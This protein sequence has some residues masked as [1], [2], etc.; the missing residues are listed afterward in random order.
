MK[1]IKLKMINFK[2]FRHAE[3]EFQDGLTG[4]I[5]NNGAGK[6]TI[7]EAILWSLYGNR[8][9]SIKKDFLKNINAMEQD[10]MSVKL[11]LATGD[12]KWSIYRGIKANGQTEASLE[13]DDKMIAWS[14]KD[15]DDYLSMKL[16]T[17]AQDFK[18]TFYARQK[19]LDNLLKEGGADKKEYLLKLLNLSDIKPR[20]IELIRTDIKE[21]EEKNIRLDEALKVI[22]DIEP[23]L[24]ETATKI[25][26][27]RTELD[28]LEKIER[29]LNSA[30][31]KCEMEIELHSKK[32]QSN[33]RLLEK[34]LAHE[35]SLSKKR[36]D[37]KHE[38]VKLFEIDN[39]K[40]HLV[41]LQPKLERHSQVKSRLDT[42][43]PIKRIYEALIKR[44]EVSDKQIEGIE[45]LLNENQERLFALQKD[46]AHL[47]KLK[48]IEEE[49]NK[50]KNDIPE[51]EILRDNYNKI[52][53]QLN[54]EKRNCISIESRISKLE[55][56]LDELKK[57]QAKLCSI[58]PIKN[59]Y[60]ALQKQIS[61]LKIQ[62]EK[63][64]K[65]D[66]LGKRREA[67]VEQIRGLSPDENAILQG[68]SRLSDL[69]VR[70]SKLIAQERDLQALGEELNGILIKLNRDSS[71]FQSKKVEA[72]ANLERVK[73]LGAEGTCP[74]CERPLSGQH[75]VLC[76]KYM[77]E[78]S[79]AEGQCTM[80]DAKIK[81]HKEGIKT[82]SRAMADLKQ[83]LESLNHDKTIRASLEAR[84]NAIL[85][86]KTG[87]QIELKAVDSS[88]AEFGTV[89]FDQVHFD[90]I[91]QKIQEIGPQIADYDSLAIRLE[92]FPITENELKELRDEQGN[93]V[94]KLQDVKERLYELRYEEP[95]YLSLKQRKSELEKDHERIISLSQKIKEIPDI[96][97]NLSLR[98]KEAEDAR[99]SCKELDQSI[100]NLG[101]N[102]LE[103]ET[104][105][106]EKTDLSRSQDEAQEIRIKLAPEADIKSR[107]DDIA[108]S[109]ED[110]E[111]D[112]AKA[113]DDINSI[114][115]DGGAHQNSKNDLVE[116]K[117][118]LEDFRPQLSRKNIE[119]GV[120]MDNLERLK[121]GESKKKDYERERSEAL[122][123]LQMLDIVKDLLD[124]FLDQILIK[125]RSDIQKS[126]GEILEEIT[127]KYNRIEIDDEFNICV[128]D[129][130]R[131][132]PITRYSGGEIDMIA[133]SVR[134]AISEYL[135]RQDRGGTGGYSFLILDEIF[136]S[137]D[138]M[139]RDNMINTLR[140][141]DT[142]F[143]QV[144]VISH[145]GDVQGQ[146]DNI[147]NVT[148]NELGDSIVD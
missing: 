74:T 82:N 75:G 137:Q 19:D 136:G 145:I 52:S 45:R 124:G 27:V 72:K 77:H 84:L 105:L 114:G 70:E 92:A 62:K 139:H 28:G 78:I 73:L 127:E 32:E 98:N 68:L 9:L 5:G 10:R 117:K 50:L 3:I 48:P 94:Q 131:P 16:H 22:G 130:G 97:A 81:S 110:L 129:G 128:E 121:R 141:L 14:V 106:K 8:A 12:Q 100:K 147:I 132:Y 108:Q 35:S 88:L 115:Y 123:N 83:S 126:A 26:T 99:K 55:K 7:V 29:E 53:S 59:D 66:D 133:V 138:L 86:R 102:S 135:M 30:V 4:I 17:N 64:D 34:I 95:K 41:E 91:S 93:S 24:E 142:R 140:R 67:L 116:C 44:K 47:V 113:K 111:K 43:E 146:F 25:N 38:D 51:M 33:K 125:I 13:I 31:Q 56:S 101:F 89:E 118:N 71:V 58:Q 144:I 46:E 49:Y 65:K 20:S 119:L 15:V 1:L 112:I 76:G 42:L 60:V 36:D 79:E 2:K 61:D 11:D 23:K 69:D 104:L 57:S 21:N 37:L 148:E 143:P 90:E 120:L 96:I 122:K 18:K 103:Y 63:K 39:H 6:S 80:I 40:K 87:I 85:D 134:I 54:E 109:I 107:R